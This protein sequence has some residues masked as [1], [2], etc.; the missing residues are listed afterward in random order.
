MEAGDL[1]IPD[2]LG[3]CLRPEAGLLGAHTLGSDG[4]GVATQFHE[5]FTDLGGAWGVSQGVFQ[6]GLAGLSRRGRDAVGGRTGRLL[7]AGRQ[8]NSDGQQRGTFT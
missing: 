2:A 6:H 7:S 4:G 1:L 8:R 3:E 5:P